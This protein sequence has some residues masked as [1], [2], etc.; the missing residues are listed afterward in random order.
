M[1]HANIYE[2]FQKIFV[3][4]KFTPPPNNIADLHKANEKYNKLVADGVI[5]K[6]GYTLRDIG[7]AHL[8][9]VKINGR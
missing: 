2:D 5:K 7:E 8:Y 3:D 1:N 6:R 4:T 9:K